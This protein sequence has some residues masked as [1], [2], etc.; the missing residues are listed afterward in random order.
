MPA[1]IYYQNAFNLPAPEEIILHFVVLPRRR[2]IWHDQASQAIIGGIVRIR[3]LRVKFY[4]SQIF[5]A[6][7]HLH[8]KKYVYRE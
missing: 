5:M 7:E 8:L 3:L 1:P 2:V 4:A 6:L